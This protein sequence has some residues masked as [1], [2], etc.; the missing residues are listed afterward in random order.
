[1]TAIIRCW[2]CGEGRLTRRHTANSVTH[3]G[4]SGSI[5][6]TSH[7]CDECGAILFSE[8]DVRENKRA[9][10]RFRKSATMAPLGCEIESMRVGAGLTQRRAAE[11]FGGGPV[12]FSKYENDD[13]VPDEAMNKLLRLAIA[14]PDIVQ[15]L[16]G[17]SRTRVSVRHVSFE[18]E[19]DSYSG[20]TSSAIAATRKLSSSIT[21]ITSKRS[22]EVKQ[23]REPS[24]TLQ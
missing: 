8:A 9:W 16:E 4:I 7:I 10:N 2:A 12:A 1:M 5:D 17:L 3:E 11:L 21:G 24:W 14:Y 13:L 22:F 23:S 19:E 18:A 6:Q 15:R 20:W